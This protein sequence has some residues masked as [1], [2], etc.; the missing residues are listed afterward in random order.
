MRAKP[1]TQFGNYTVY[2][3]T[4][5]GGRAPGLMHDA[6]RPFV[7]THHYHGSYKYGGRLRRETIGNYETRAAAR[8]A[9]Y[10]HGAR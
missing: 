5:E 3:G 1:V 7:V 8:S 10:R 6:A 9:M 2:D 4:Q